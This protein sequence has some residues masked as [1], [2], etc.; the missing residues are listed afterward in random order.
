MSGGGGKGGTS[1]QEIDPALTAAA[2]DALDFA[3][4]GAAVPYS[5]NRGVQFSAFTP[6]QEAGMASADQ[7]AAAFG[8]PSAGGGSAM[9]ATQTSASGI[10]GYSTAEDFDQMKDQS[11]APGLQEALAKLFADPQTGEFNGP[12][13]PL[14]SGRYA[15]MPGVGGGGK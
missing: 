1:K 2:R 10:E 6:Q 9:P 8:M 13:G 4:A 12:Q 14:F 7:A 15:D 3:A 11:M 5:P